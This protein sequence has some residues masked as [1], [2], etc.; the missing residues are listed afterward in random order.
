[1]LDQILLDKIHEFSDIC[2]LKESQGIIIKYSLYS[3][4]RRYSQINLYK[5]NR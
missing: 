2:I 5:L 3:T 1:M 4:I